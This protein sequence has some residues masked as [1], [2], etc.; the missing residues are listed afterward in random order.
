MSRKLGGVGGEPGAKA[1]SKKESLSVKVRSGCNPDC[2][3]EC[4]YGLS[5]GRLWSLVA[6]REVLHR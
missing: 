2:G 4:E 5:R 1:S 3:V 6:D